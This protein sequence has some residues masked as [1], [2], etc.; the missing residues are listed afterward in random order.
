MAELVISPTGVSNRR[1]ACETWA[2][3]GKVS[4][5]F[6]IPRLGQVR[7]LQPGTSNSTGKSRFAVSGVLASLLGNF[8][9]CWLAIGGTRR[10]PPLRWLDSRPTGGVCRSGLGR[11][12]TRLPTSSCPRLG[13]CAATADLRHY[14]PARQVDP[15]P[16]PSR[17]RRLPALHRRLLLPCPAPAEACQTRQTRC[18]GSAD[19]IAVSDSDAPESLSCASLAHCTA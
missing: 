2:K 11:A 16:P 5:F 13:C 3:S 19:A 1:W 9:R 18:P 4:L 17:Q 15:A 6:C 7:E 14:T 8:A 10:I 12:V